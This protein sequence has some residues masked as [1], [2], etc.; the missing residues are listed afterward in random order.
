MASNQDSTLLEASGGYD[1][2]EDDSSGISS[3]SSSSGNSSSSSN[4]SYNQ[5][6]A[7]IAKHER[8][9]VT[10]QQKKQATFWRGGTMKEKATAGWTRNHNEVVHENTP[11]R[12]VTG[13]NEQEAISPAGLTTTDT[14]AMTESRR[15][16]DVD[17]Q[18][19]KDVSPISC[20][21]AEEDDTRGGIS[22]TTVCNV[23]SRLFQ[24][25]TMAVG[26]A[27]SGNSIGTG[28]WVSTL[29]ATKNTQT[30]NEDERPDS[31]G[32]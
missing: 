26:L 6:D 7:L 10:I 21:S 24:D 12:R 20:D 17:S 9:L 1:N 31:D 29:N 15:V 4:T 8:R 18:S 3:N 22:A 30:V 16:A 32:N 23:A 28:S 5:R 11:N 27:V 25:T 14:A 19:R 13:R 2:N